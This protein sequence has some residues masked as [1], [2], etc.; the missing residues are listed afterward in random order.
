MSCLANSYYIQQCDV[1][2]TDTDYCLIAVHVGILY[3]GVF[4]AL[5]FPL[6]RLLLPQRYSNIFLQPEKLLVSTRETTD[7]PLIVNGVLRA[8][9]KHRPALP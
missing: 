5:H 9:T 7:L 8:H 6:Y 4:Q 1:I 3:Q 2:S